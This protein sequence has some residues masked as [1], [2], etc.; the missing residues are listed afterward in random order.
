MSDS[1]LA[2]FLASLVAGGGTFLAAKWLL[3]QAMAEGFCH[4]RRQRFFAVYLLSFVLAGGAFALQVWLGYVVYSTEGLFAACVTG[5]AASQALWGLFEAKEIKPQPQVVRL[6]P[7]VVTQIPKPTDLRPVGSLFP[8]NIA[9]ALVAAGFRTGQ[10]I[11]DAGRADLLDKLAAQE[12]GPGAV[13]KIIE[14]VNM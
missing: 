5:F 11:K 14:T 4:T 1:S 12:L 10:E 9:Q 3:Q 6:E 7:L 13:D 8:K 2:S